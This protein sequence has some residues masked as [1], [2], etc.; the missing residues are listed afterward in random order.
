[1]QNMWDKKGIT[2]IEMIIAATIFIF[3]VVIVIYY[4]SFIGLH[5][6]PSNILFNSLE[7]KLRNESEINY[8]TIYL[9]VSSSTSNRCFNIS[10]HADMSPEENFNF[11]RENGRAVKFN[12]SENG[13]W[14]LVSQEANQ[15][16]YFIYSFPFNVTKPHRLENV[17]CTS[18]AKGQGYNYSVTYQDK[19]FVYENLTGLGKYSYGELK[20][21][22]KFQK[23]FSINVTN[24]ETNEIIFSI[25]GIK[26]L[27]TQVKAK[28]FP[29]RLINESGAIFDG[30][31]NL[32]VW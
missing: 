17:V 32:Q 14:L 12:V 15:N 30:I 10:L 21:R 28:Q 6:E 9:T 2:N 31:I 7:Q 5:E 26:A 27:Q 4:V 19:I 24:A 13:E 25:G 23:D 18:L 11:I 3:C 1:M 20:K 16:S 29:I 8:K 22:W